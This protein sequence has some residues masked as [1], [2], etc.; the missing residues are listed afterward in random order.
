MGCGILATLCPRTD[1]YTVEDVRE[2]KTPQ[3]AHSGPRKSCIACVLPLGYLTE[4]G[5]ELFVPLNYSSNTCRHTGY[6]YIY[7]SDDGIG[8]GK[9]IT[10][11]SSPLASESPSSML[12]SI[13]RNRARG[14][15]RPSGTPPPLALKN[16]GP[17]KNKQTSVSNVL[18]RQQHLSLFSHGVCR[19]LVQRYYKQLC[20]TNNLPACKERPKSKRQW[21]SVAAEVAAAELAA[22]HVFTVTAKR[23]FVVQKYECYKYLGGTPGE[24]HK[25]GTPRASARW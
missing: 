16:C 8:C 22:V 15:T 3:H 9:P 20:L 13:L 6:T 11:T 25:Q 10:R 21:R 14:R 17:M 1:I 4:R 7:K 19:S 2:K 5:R 24:A 18:Q 23:H 12:S